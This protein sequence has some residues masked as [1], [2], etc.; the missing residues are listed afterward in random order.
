MTNS[1]YKRF[2]R[3]LRRS[4]PS[5]V[6][7]VA[8]VVALVGVPGV[9]AGGLLVT[10]KQIK[11]NSI[12][13]A[14]LRKSAVKTSDL[15]T[16]AVRS[17][18]IQTGAVESADIGEGE[19]TPGDV[20]MPDPIQLQVTSPNAIEANSDFALVAN[21]GTYSKVDPTSVL[22]VDWTGTA[23]SP[24]GTDCLFQLRVDG[25][26]S[27]PTGGL[28]FVASG[29]AIGVSA[30]AIFSNL[31]PGPHTVQVWARDARTSGPTRCI[32]GPEEAGIAQTFV[33]G[34]LVV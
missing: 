4:Y 33:V 22:Q 34:E 20:T 26:P 30:S 29:P 16:G 5:I 27:S 17:A 13:S 14:D 31:P 9:T 18:D 3:V 7:T 10:S 11:N 21:A 19:V 25:Q 24:F 2:S 1:A 12:T 23:R 8:L 32:V 28:L 15:G 6:A